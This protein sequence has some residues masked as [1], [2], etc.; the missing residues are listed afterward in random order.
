VRDQLG[1]LHRQGEL[2]GFEKGY[3]A[4][5]ERVHREMDGLLGQV[6]DVRRELARRTGLAEGDIELPRPPPRRGIGGEVPTLVE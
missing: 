6:K 4:R 3:G 2:E 1:I 5:L